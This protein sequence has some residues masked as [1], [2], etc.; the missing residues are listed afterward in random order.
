LANSAVLHA[1]ETRWSL[2]SVWALL[3]EKARV[4]LYGVPKDAAT[5]ALLVDAEQFPGI[6]ISDNAAV[7][8]KFNRVQKCWAHLLR[9]AIRLTLLAP[10][11]AEYRNFTD[12]LYA[13]Y[14]QARQAQQDGRLKEAGRTRRISE[15]D[16]AIFDLCAPVWRAELPKSEG[17]EDD[18]RLLCNE[19]MELMLGHALFTFVGAAP[20]DTP[21][22]QSVPLANTNNEAERTLR[23]PA[24]ARNTG[25]G[26]KTSRGAR[27]QTILVSVL[28]SLR[29]YLPRYTLAAV[30]EEVSDWLARSCSR[31]ERM[32]QA[33][34]LSRPPTLILS[35]LYPAV[36]V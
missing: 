14:L 21:L 11:N 25:R 8:R 20:I 16:D 12:R 10:D 31:F 23:S 9:K 15:L 1:D 35:C 33:L 32:C 28:E 27:R 26:N 2:R 3:T 4:L 7:Y 18:Y 30:I 24:L 17:L 6:C 5:L 13:I 22:G 29:C 19:L 36:S 34:N